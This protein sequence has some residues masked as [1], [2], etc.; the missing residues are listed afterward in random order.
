MQPG[1]RLRP[2]NVKRITYYVKKMG[3]RQFRILRKDLLPKQAE[4]LGKT[5]HVILTDHVVLNGLIRAISADHLMLENSRSGRH[6][7][8]MATIAE[9]VY[10]Q[11][12]EY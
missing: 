3:K 5:G 11:E 10:D 9:V 7:L 2:K 6:Q 1:F 12:T 4:M 8:K